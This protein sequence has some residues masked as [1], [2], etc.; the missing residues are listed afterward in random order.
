M[1]QHEEIN[2]L[3][4]TQLEELRQ[5]LLAKRQELV[6]SINVMRS[7]DIEVNPDDNIEEIDQASANQIQTVQLR[8]LEK[9]YKLL[10]E[11]NRAL[12][13]FD[14]GEYGLCEGTEDPIGYP[15]LK[16]RPWARY[17]ID[18]AEEKERMAK[19][20]SNRLPGR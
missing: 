15:R 5:L 6:R 13:K 14:S 20:A 3:T 8:V 11:V 1:M 2:G 16:V 12:D 7:R 9:E 17:S 19:Q 18:Y 4:E 10:R